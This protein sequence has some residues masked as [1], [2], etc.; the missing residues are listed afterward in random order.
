MI[1]SNFPINALFCVLLI[2]DVG[3]DGNGVGGG[4]DDDGDGD[5]GG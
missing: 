2:Q 1:R 5:V 4:G 3:G